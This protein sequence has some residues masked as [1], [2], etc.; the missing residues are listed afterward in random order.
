MDTECELY[1]TLTLLPLLFI[2]QLSPEIIK[3]NYKSETQ[4]V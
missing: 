2:K 1:Q 4:R 3:F